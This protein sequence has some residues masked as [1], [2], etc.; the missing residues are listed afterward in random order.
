MGI[1]VQKACLVVEEMEI[2]AEAHLGVLYEG[3]SNT[4]NNV[5]EL[6]CETAE[7]KSMCLEGTV[8]EI[9]YMKS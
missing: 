5:R 8:Y 7:T 1:V 6:S 9:V 4:I 2:P 3:V